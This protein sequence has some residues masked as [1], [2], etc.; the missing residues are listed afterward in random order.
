MIFKLKKTN[1]ITRYA[2]FTSP[3]SW[4]DLAMRISELFKFPLEDVIVTYVTNKEPVGLA[5][6][7]ELQNFYNSLRLEV[8]QIDKEIKF[9]VQD[10]ENFDS[11]S[12]VDSPMFH[13]SYLLPLGNTTI[14]STWSAGS[15]L[16]DLCNDGRQSPVSIEIYSI[17]GAGKVSLGCLDL[18]SPN[19]LLVEVENHQTVSK[20]KE[21]IAK[22]MQ[23]EFPHNTLNLWN[24]SK[25][26]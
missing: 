3:P 14:T 21:L 11:G 2:I 10:R 1:A 8:D 13:I 22:E 9:V 5:N 19:P 25:H 7:K 6:D 18:N 17:V 26:S 23:Y 15:N 16:S 12:A 20:L 4:D 24:V